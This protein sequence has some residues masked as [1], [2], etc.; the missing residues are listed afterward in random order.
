MKRGFLYLVMFHVW[1]AAK[2]FEP[3]EVLLSISFSLI[4]MFWKMEMGRG[5]KE[6]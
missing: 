2:H 5:E 1:V 6:C 3:V 4:Q